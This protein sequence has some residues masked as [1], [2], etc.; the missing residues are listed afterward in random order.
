MSMA[1]N[2]T[3]Y[4]NKITKIMYAFVGIVV[5]SLLINLLYI[6]NKVIKPSNEIIKNE[7]IEIQKEEIYKE[8]EFVLKALEIL[9]VDYNITSSYIP[10]RVKDKAISII[11]EYN[12]NN[13]N[14]IFALDEGWNLIIHPDSSVLNYYN[15]NYGHIIYEIKNAID[16]GNN[17]VSYDNSPKGEFGHDKNL[18][19]SYVIYLPEWE[20]T[21]GSGYLYGRINSNADKFI[22]KVNILVNDNKLNILFINLFLIFITVLFSVVSS[23]GIRQEIDEYNEDI[24]QGNEKIHRM[25][26][27]LDSHTN[28]DPIT[29]IPN[30][31][32]AVNFLD[33]VKEISKNF[34]YYVHIFEIDGF[35]HKNLISGCN[36]RESILKEFSIS[37]KE[38]KLDN[39]KLFH[40]EYDRFVLLTENIK[41]GTEE[42]QSIIDKLDESLSNVLLCGNVSKISFVSANVKFDNKNE[43]FDSILEKGEYALRYAKSN[44]LNYLHYSDEIE[45]IRDREVGL[46]FELM[47]AIQKGEL[48][49]HYQPQFCSNSNQV[50]GLEA[51]V[52]WNNKNYGE[53]SPA[54]FIPLAENKGQIHDIGNFVIRSALIDMKKIGGL[55]MTINI[56]PVELLSPNF[57]SFIKSTVKDLKVDTSKLIFD[58]T[59]QILV[60]DINKASK[61]MHNLKDLGI[62]FSISSVGIGQSSFKYLCE[63]PIDEIKIPLEIVKKIDSHNKYQSFIKSAIYFANLTG[64]R[65][66]LEG[67]E[68][69][70]QH[71]HIAGLTNAYVQGFN[72]SKAKPLDEIVKNIK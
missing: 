38:I 40:I 30:K 70:S 41:G 12:K 54:E 20:M 26:S 55:A 23:L 56:L 43:N 21:I 62:R 7:Y 6:S 3:N 2:N 4:L 31:K 45:E 46:S 69:E 60:N 49:V 28:R 1:A 48:Y 13:D 64:V 27:I 66:V 58:I 37:L 67:V 71:K 9:K 22:H 17:W 15:E 59:K 10:D 52:R 61:V 44:K 24:L 5:V 65:I 32:S 34:N 19:Y 14:F 63:L 68:T 57:E 16:S 47:S 18:K 25:L 50:I 33:T 39:Q 11:N 51:L 72:L 36:S 8:V 53:V 42:T 29:N 35:N